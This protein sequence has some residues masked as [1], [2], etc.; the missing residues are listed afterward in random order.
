MFLLLK[1]N[2][3]T[4][5]GAKMKTYKILPLILIFVAFSMSGMA[6]LSATNS[7]SLS[8]YFNDTITG[9]V[10][11]SNTGAT[12]I[13]S[14]QS[15]MSNFAGYNYEITDDIAGQSIAAGAQ[16]TFKFRVTIPQ[17]E[18]NNH[19][20]HQIGTI[21]FT[22]SN[23]TSV[24][25]TSTVNMEVR[26]R[27][28]ITD[29]DI[30]VDDDDESVSEGETIDAKRGDSITLE[31]E[32][33]NKFSSSSNNDFDNVDITVYNDDL[34]IDEDKEID[35]DSGDEETVS[36]SFSIDDDADDGRETVEIEARGY[37]ED[38]ILHIT[39]F[40][41]DLDIEVP[42]EEVI[43]RDASFSPSIVDCDDSAVLNIEIK[44]TGKK[45]LDDAMI[46][47]DSDDIDFELNELIRDIEIDEEDTENIQLRVNIPDDLKEGTYIFDIIS[48]HGP[49]SND[50]SDTSVVLL[51]KIK[52]TPPT[53]SDS[54]GTSD[55]TTVDDTEEEIIVNQGNSGTVLPSNVVYAE[56]K[57]TKGFDFDNGTIV[58]LVLVNLIIIGAIIG[59]TAAIFKKK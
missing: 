59:V 20:S 55:D 47:I 3:K 58:L 22:G 53:V 49:S 37:D 11:I 10:T 57:S 45:D 35:I 18:L 50:D 9:T 5:P 31:I 24:S 8:G 7:L 13:T 33:D 28:A 1:N 2:K 4:H 12:T 15:S 54:T 48:Y 36:F 25:D 42:S 41:F 38:G 27:L 44:N 40:E 39:V 17:S 23:G 51:E 34:D 6:T 21:T 29:V 30:T 56:P 19:D 16:A 46:E 52:C 14:L 26:P 32:L 43:I